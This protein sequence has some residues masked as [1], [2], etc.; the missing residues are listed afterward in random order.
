MIT[1]GSATFCFPEVLTY[2]GIHLATFLGR[3]SRKM[4]PGLVEREEGPTFQG[5]PADPPVSCHLTANTLNCRRD[6]ERA[7]WSLSETEREK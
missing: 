3:R 4:T 1:V 6:P 5:H 7:A 2:R